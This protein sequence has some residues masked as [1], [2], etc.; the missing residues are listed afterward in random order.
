MNRPIPQGVT[1]FR[2]AASPILPSGSG[3]RHFMVNGKISLRQRRPSRQKQ[4]VKSTD[5]TP[6]SPLE[7]FLPLLQIPPQIIVTMERLRT[8]G[9]TA[10]IAKIVDTLAR[11]WARSTKSKYGIRIGR[12]RKRPTETTAMLCAAKVE[13]WLAIFHPAIEKKRELQKRYRNL[14]L[15]KEQLI[16]SRYDPQVA[17]IVISNVTAFQ[18]A[19]AWVGASAEPRRSRET[20][21]NYSRRYR[22]FVWCYAPASQ[23]DSSVPKSEA[24]EIRFFTDLTDKIPLPILASVHFKS[25]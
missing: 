6:P 5:A 23:Q 11:D 10:Q 22:R 9:K 14:S 21:A 19:C 25:R 3:R 8:S 16:K 17:E 7:S 24:V 12:P 4:V 20:I 1:R 13:G 18:A 2:P 15:V